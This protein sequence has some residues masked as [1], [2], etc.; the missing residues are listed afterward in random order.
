M[1]EEG[2]VFALTQNLERSF[3][4]HSLAAGSVLLFQERGKRCESLVKMLKTAMRLIT[5]PNER[6]FITKSWV[7][8]LIRVAKDSGANIS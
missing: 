4:T 7:E 6:Q 1:K 3:K 8:R 5:S 2:V